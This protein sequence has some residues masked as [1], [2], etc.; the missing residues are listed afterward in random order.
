MESSPGRIYDYRDNDLKLD[1]GV[2]AR[3]NRSSGCIC[4][5]ITILTSIVSLG[6]LFIGIYIMNW[7]LYW[8][9]PY[10]TLLYKPKSADTMHPSP[11]AVV[12]PLIDEKQTFD[13][14]ATVWLQT[15]DSSSESTI[16]TLPAQKAIFTGKVFHGMTLRDKS[17]HTTVNYTVPTEIFKNLDLKTY[18]LRASFVLLPT[19]PSLLDNLSNYSSWRNENFLVPHFRPWPDTG[20]APTL[21]DKA[22]DSFGVSIG[23]VRFSGIQSRCG[24]TTNAANASEHAQEDDTGNE[25]SEDSDEIDTIE[26]DLKLGD[27]FTT[28]KGKP[29][30]ESH[31]YIVTH[32]YINAVDMTKFYDHKAYDRVHKLKTNTCGLAS[33]LP[34]YDWGPCNLRF[35][36]V[37]D[38][39]LQLKIAEEGKSKKTKHWAYAPSLSLSRIA[40]TPKDLVPVP[41]NREDCTKSDRFNDSEP[42]LPDQEFVDISWQIVYSGR[43]HLKL[44]LF[45]GYPWVS[46]YNM[47]ETK[48]VQQEVQHSAE[49]ILGLFGNQV[50]K[51][52]HPRRTF[53]ISMLGT[54][55][56]IIIKVTDILYWHTRSTTIGIS[57]FATILFAVITLGKYLLMILSSYN[58]KEQLFI[59]LFAI[60]ANLPL[61]LSPFLMLKVI[62]RMEFG[63]NQKKGKGKWTENG[64]KMKRSRCGSGVP[65][66]GINF[67]KATH[68]ERASDRLD[69]RTSWT[70]KLSLFISCCLAYFFF[71]PT[72]SLFVI[73]PLGLPR[74]IDEHP[75]LTIVRRSLIA[76]GLIIGPGLQ[77]W[78]NYQ[79][80]TFAGKYKLNAVLDGISLMLNMSFYSSWVLGNTEFRDGFSVHHLMKAFIVVG[81]CYQAVVLPTVSQGEVDDEVE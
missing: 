24:L 7:I 50:R 81:W 53:L 62:W 4:V 61:E 26:N 40:W 52:S 12:R 78:F 31:P 21:Q 27:F 65:I 2:P 28:S 22:I 5:L 47:T 51:G 42:L 16:S 18:D 38:T 45:D 67:A 71:S 74:R 23:L 20:P 32:S 48:E 59:T 76:P 80:R 13:I 57:R 54:I 55:I 68:A 29:V 9:E 46:D 72:T 56:G 60:I 66:P 63:W 33:S 19:S 69:A 39:R 8:R 77:L 14:V 43:S 73:A 34:S 49:I 79:S 6:A 75:L 17:V 35:H 3:R 25:D 41:V 64:K 15:N 36:E 44:M 30:L 70:V 10:A 1:P 11:R 58:L 37:V